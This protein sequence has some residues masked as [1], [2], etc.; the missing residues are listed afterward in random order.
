MHSVYHVCVDGTANNA[1]IF[2]SYTVFSLFSGKAGG[3]GKA[4]S[5]G[6]KASSKLEGKS[7]AKILKKEGVLRLDNV[8]SPTTADAL[9]TYLYNLRTQSEQ[10]VADGKV[11]PI[12]R[13]AHVLLKHNRCDL[14]IPL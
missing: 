14:T 5:N 4:S 3:F 8:L 11:Q 7:Y 9:R 12:E 6:T 1:H 13:Y 10:D 2:T